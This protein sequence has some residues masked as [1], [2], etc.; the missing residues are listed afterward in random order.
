MQGGIPC[1]VGRLRSVEL[2]EGDR[3][4]G[5]LA[6]RELDEFDVFG[7]EPF[8]GGHRSLVVVEDLEIVPVL[9]QEAERR[10]DP[11]EGEGDTT[12]DRQDPFLH[13]CRTLFGGR[14]HVGVGHVCRDNHKG[15][16][17]N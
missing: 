4:P 11:I 8:V 16:R 3:V 10:P 12:D 1:P 17:D 9:D 2:L 13:Q 14:V 15:H 6:V 7:P 5:G